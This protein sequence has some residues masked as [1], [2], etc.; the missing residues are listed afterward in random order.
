MASNLSAH[1]SISSQFIQLKLTAADSRTPFH[2][3]FVK[4]DN[5]QL[6]DCGYMTWYYKCFP[7]FRSQPSRI[8]SHILVLIFF[9]EL[10]MEYWRVCGLIIQQD[11]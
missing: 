7:L 8:R 2:M 6:T 3:L 4:I 1:S 5:Q 11:F 9:I 10:F